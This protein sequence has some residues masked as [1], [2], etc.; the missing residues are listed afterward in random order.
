MR[1]STN[2]KNE[3][4]ERAVGTLLSAEVKAAVLDNGQ[5]WVAPAFVVN[6]WYLTA[7]EPIRDIERRIIG[8]LYV[9]TLERPYLD[10]AHDV[11]F[12]FAGIA[13]LCTVFLLVILYFSTTRII[14]PL[15]RMAAA[16]R[17]VAGGGGL[18]PEGRGRHP[19]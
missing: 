1:I 3:R 14:R 7:Y 18:D 4:G 11:V 16:A 19:R 6:D 10:T 2:V 13:A 12:T 8:I 9:G 5:P 17:R 15:R